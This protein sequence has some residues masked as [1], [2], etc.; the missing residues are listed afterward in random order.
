MPGWTLALDIPAGLSGLGAFLD[1]L[2]EEVAEAGGRVY[3]AKDSRLS[4]ATFRRM[5]PRLEEF[6]A[7]RR[8]VDPNGI[9]NSDLARRLELI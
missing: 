5:Y 4:A 7:V 8:K 1:E 2:D 3:L 9:F 6:L